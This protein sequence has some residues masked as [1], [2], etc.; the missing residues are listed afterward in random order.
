MKKK[1]LRLNGTLELKNIDKAL[2]R[3]NQ[4]SAWFRRAKRPANNP[5]AG[6]ALSLARPQTC[7]T[8]QANMH[9]EAPVSI[10][11]LDIGTKNNITAAKKIMII[12][13]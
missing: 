3:T 4:T 5:A 12:S 6:Q 8:P 2:A 7:L 1:A 13:I 11:A 10:A 9:T